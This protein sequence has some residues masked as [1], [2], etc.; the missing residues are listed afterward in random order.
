MYFD[1]ERKLPFA[2][3][4]GCQNL[5]CASERSRIVELDSIRYFQHAWLARRKS[6]FSRLGNRLFLVL[7]DING[8]KCIY[9]F[10]EIGGPFFRE[11][12][13]GSFVGIGVV[14]VGR[15]NKLVLH[16]NVGA[17]NLNILT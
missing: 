10:A 2:D 11:L 1:K 16:E 17:P 13:G 5:L 8:Y 12:R 6:L 3:D 9:A 14:L 15:D 4:F 7:E